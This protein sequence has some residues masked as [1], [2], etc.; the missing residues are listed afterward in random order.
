MKISTVSI[1]NI[2]LN[3]DLQ[4]VN[5][6]LETEAGNGLSSLH[7]GHWMAVFSVLHLLLLDGCVFCT[8]LAVA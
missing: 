2:V 7:N 3:V 6:F 1:V 4:S 8:A 5:L